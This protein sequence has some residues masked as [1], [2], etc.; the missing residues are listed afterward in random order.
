MS[1]ADL[2]P[3]EPERA[4]VVETVDEEE[5]YG[6]SQELLQNIKAALAEADIPQVEALIEPLHPADVAD[7]IEHLDPEE[8][9]L[10]L[11][12][13]K[14]VIEAET[15]SHLEDTLREEVVDQ[16]KPEELAE[17]VSELDSD[18]AVEILENL[19]E[20][21]QQ[22]VLDVI[23][24]EDR[25][26]LE[27]GLTFPEDSAG[28]L[29]QRE[30]VAVPLHWNVGQ[31]IDFLRNTKDLPD[32]FYSL[33]V[34]DRL[35]K[36]AGS[37]ALSRAIRSPRDANLSDIMET[38]LRLVPADMDQEAVAY[39]FRQY[40]L[41]SAPVVDDGGKLIG[42]VTV[43]DVVRVIDEEAEEDLLAIVGVGDTDFHDPAHIT[44]FRRIQW[45]VVTLINTLIAVAVIS[46]F[47]GM[48]GQF[49]S[50]AVL[51]PITAAMGGNAGVQVITVTVR[52]LATKDITP[53][54]NVWRIIAKELLVGLMNACIFALILGTI[55][56]LWYGHIEL[57]FVL[58]AAMIFNMVWAGFAG[59]VIPLVMDRLGLDPATGAG[60]FLTTTTDCLGF[61]SFLGLA[62]L[63]L[64]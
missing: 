57:G 17:V 2:Q 52:A 20:E 40:A 59:T 12:I 46:R 31:T 18:D 53:N 14:H 56:A 29:M 48:I 60:P 45:L 35:H 6:P 32:D 34:V 39:M 28:R 5:L 42:V 38:E 26:A 49:P 62:T 27:Q 9:R 10:F 1:P 3:N 25:V 47:E 21:R 44:A 51:M 23:P 36:P 16:M 13:T 61:F 54:S 19:D 8:R 4:P 58:A 63:F 7:L 50:L 11:E 41:I 24:Q 43:D 64:R 22:Q 55:G 37:V 33:Y 15:I 30:L